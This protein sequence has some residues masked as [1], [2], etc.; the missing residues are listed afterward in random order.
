[1]NF[2][3]VLI[4]TYGR[5]GSTLLQGLLN[6]IDNCL[7]RGENNNFCYGLFN[8][9]E[10]LL[11]A[12][13][14]DFKKGQNSLKV[15]SPWFGA[16]FFDENRFIKDARKLVFN[17]L[18][19]DKLKLSCIGFKE[20]RYANKEIDSIR[21]HEYLNFLEK[22]FPNPAFIF[23][24]RDH[25]QVL[26]SGWWKT[27]NK[28]KN[29]AVL[30]KFEKNIALYCINKSN[31]FTIDY[32]DMVNRSEKLHDMLRFLGAPYNDINIKKVLDIK[33]SF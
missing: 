17:Q 33:H 11:K 6:S 2:S 29:K 19:P 27:M 16:A 31:V 4:V 10:A 20:I 21:L 25:D 12:K 28:E 13:E 7:I 22:L 5:S 1:M 3:S 18:N 9:Y 30:E 23:L 15:K 24:T 32:A 8:A 14:D 26:N